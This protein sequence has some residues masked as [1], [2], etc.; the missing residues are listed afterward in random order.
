MK[1]LILIVDDA[2]INREL[3]KEIFEEQYD[4]LEARDGEEAIELMK[5][6]AQ[7]ISLVFLDLVMPKKDGIEVLSFMRAG[8]L[9][10]RIPVIMITGEAT[11]ESDYKAYEYGAA[12]I[13]YKPFATPV[14]MRRAENLIEQY[15]SRVHIEEELVQ[16]TAELRESQEK[17]EKN[18]EFLIN[19][20]GSVVE[21]R[22]SESGEHIQRVKYITKVLLRYCMANYPKYGLT[23]QKI[24]MMSQAAA[25]H[26]VGKIAIADSILKKPG[27]LTKKEFEEMKK[28]T[29]Y[30]CDILEQFKQEDSD[31]YKYCY[32]ICRWHHEKYDGKG[33]PDGLVGEAI[34]IHAQIVA[35]ADCFDALVS[36]RVYKDAYATSTAYDMIY[37]GECGQ[38]SDTVLDCFEMARMDLFDMV[39]NRS[40]V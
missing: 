34:P 23:E 38:F 24:E 19:A 3:L 5:R 32:E 1:D 18:N 7:D 4:I 21:F 37:R 33:Y 35:V 40:Y 31:F 29:T 12:D 2:D 30:G 16:R 25:L 15:K 36:K 39:E 14:V 28:H 20:L 10:E 9:I 13:I 26:D 6:R 11:N 17:L 27:K 22:S 8:E